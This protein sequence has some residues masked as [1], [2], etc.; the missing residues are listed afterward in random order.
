MVDAHLA[1]GSNEPT[2]SIEIEGFVNASL[3]LDGSTYSNPSFVKG[4]ADSFL[5]L[6]DCKRFT[7]IGPIQTAEWSLAHIYQVGYSNLEVE[8]FFLSVVTHVL[9]VICRV[10]LACLA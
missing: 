5:L 6:A 7:D 9:L 1:A 8:F 10:C 4:V 2:G 3:L